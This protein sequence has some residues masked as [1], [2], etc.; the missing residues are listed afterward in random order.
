MCWFAEGVVEKANPKDPNSPDT[1]ALVPT[2]N[3]PASAGSV[4]LPVAPGVPAG[5]GWNC[6]ENQVPEKPRVPPGAPPAP[7]A[8]SAP[9]TPPRASG[10]HPVASWRAGGST[11]TLMRLR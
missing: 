8:H 1:D 3:H 6:D 9:R 2:T 10:E 7:A 5:I 4:L 11:P